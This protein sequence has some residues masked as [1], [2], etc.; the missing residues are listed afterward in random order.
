MWHEAIHMISLISNDNLKISVIIGTLLYVF[1]SREH[2]SKLEHRDYTPL[3]PI[4]SGHIPC[5]LTFL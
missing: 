3:R 1:G 2:H 5:S 4:P